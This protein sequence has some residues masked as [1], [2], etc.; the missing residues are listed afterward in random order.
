MTSNDVKNI[1]NKI[2]NILLSKQ[3]HNAIPFITQLVNDTSSWQLHDNLNQIKIEYKYLLD[4]LGI[5]GVVLPED[6]FKLGII[7]KGE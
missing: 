3:I 1:K 5:Q 2:Y 4:Y 7:N 6:T